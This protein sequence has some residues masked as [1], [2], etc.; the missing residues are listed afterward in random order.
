MNKHILMYSIIISGICIQPLSAML[1]KRIMLR[2][3]SIK[4]LGLQ[5]NKRNLVTRLNL[6]EFTS[7][8]Q[9]YLLRYPHLNRLPH[10]ST[11]RI[12]CE[13]EAQSTHNHTCYIW[14]FP[15]ENNS[16]LHSK[17]RNDSESL[18]LL[19]NREENNSSLRSIKRNGSEFLWHLDDRL[20]YASLGKSVKIQDIKIIIPRILYATSSMSFLTFCALNNTYMDVLFLGV[21]IFSTLGA[22]L[23]YENP[24]NRNLLHQILK[25]SSRKERENALLEYYQLS[26]TLVN[27]YQKKQK[28]ENK[29]D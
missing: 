16:S 11:L 25:N 9:T 24:T 4:F 23:Y 12:A 29:A 28:K 6:P 1:V 7:T 15:E 20:E 22:T 17:K 10:N 26:N 18:W 14:N 13:E 2:H 21:G 27:E 3:T 5:K 19:D 8:N